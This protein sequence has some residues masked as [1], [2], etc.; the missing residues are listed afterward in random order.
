M[1]SLIREKQRLKKTVEDKDTE[2]EDLKREIQQYK[3]KVEE[4]EAKDVSLQMIVLPA[5]SSSLEKDKPP[6]SHLANLPARPP[7]PEKKPQP[8]SILANLPARSNFTGFET[9]GGNTAPKASLFAPT[10]FSPKNPPWSAPLYAGLEP[11]P[12]SNIPPTLPTR[13]GRRPKG[14]VPPLLPHHQSFGASHMPSP[15]LASPALSQDLDTP[16]LSPATAGTSASTKFPAARSNKYF[17]G[18]VFGNIPVPQGALLP[19]MSS[20]P[21]SSFDFNRQSGKDSV[22]IGPEI[23]SLTDS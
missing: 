7:A 21:P 14:R 4:L 22:R 8:I 15:A 18:Q 13:L 9:T 11:V 2:I 17:H 5:H 10:A 1:E 20:S 23:Q 12:E 3:S 19:H 16:N 6:T